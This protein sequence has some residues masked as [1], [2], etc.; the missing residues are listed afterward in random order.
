MQ[1]L[2][3]TSLTNESEK[4]I[5][6]GV[7]LMTFSPSFEFVVCHCIKHRQTPLEKKGYKGSQKEPILQEIS[8]INRMNLLNKPKLK[9]EDY[10]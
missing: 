1:T 2:H 5:P 8:V 9:T 6:S 3:T 4:M 10:S 7:T